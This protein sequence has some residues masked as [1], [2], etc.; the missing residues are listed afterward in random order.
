MLHYIIMSCYSLLH[1][2]D[3]PLTLRH[4][5]LPDVSNHIVFRYRLEMWVTQHNLPRHDVK[6]QVFT[7]FHPTWGNVTSCSAGVFSVAKRM[8][9]GNLMVK[10]GRAGGEEHRRARAYQLDSWPSFTK[11][12]QSALY[13]SMRA[14]VR[15]WEQAISC[16]WP[17]MLWRK[18]LVWEKQCS[19]DLKMRFIRG[20]KTVAKR[21]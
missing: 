1:T 21:R 7:C 8:F 20:Q 2:H 12:D 19:C 5:M 17:A 4:L 13:S 18:Q 6:L 14:K 3:L 11:K 10:T 9:V 15:C 16:M